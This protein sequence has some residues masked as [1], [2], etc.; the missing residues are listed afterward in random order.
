MPPN[1]EAYLQVVTVSI[2]KTSGLFPSLVNIRNPQALL[3]LFY[4]TVDY[5]SVKYLMYFAFQKLHHAKYIF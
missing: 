1:V 5:I 2:P 3:A 4:T